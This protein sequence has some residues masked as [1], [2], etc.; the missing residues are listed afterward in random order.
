MLQ[1]FLPF[2]LVA[3]SAVSAQELGKDWEIE[4]L[5]WDG[6]VKT[7]DV[8]EVRNPFGDVRARGTPEQAVGISAMVQK[9]VKDSHRLDFKI[10]QDPGRLLIE[11]VYPGDLS[12]TVREGGK[13]RADVT[14]YVPFGSP[15]SVRIFAGLIEA[16][17]LKSDVDFE[18]DKGKIFLRLAGHVR[19]KTRQADTVAYLLDTAFVKP[20]SFENQVGSTTVYLPSNASLAVTATTSGELTTDYSIDVE[21]APG[22]WLKKAK[23][24]IGGGEHGLTLDSK[25]GPIKILSGKWDVDG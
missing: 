21:R 23:A 14:V 4:R 12:E 25:N 6:A 3:V 2:T 22:A 20:A 24:V 17:G 11:V 8:I 15:Y 1:Y 10:T 16:K 9:N 5:T 13:R 18:S 19:L 7:G